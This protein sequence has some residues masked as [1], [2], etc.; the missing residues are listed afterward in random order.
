MLEELTHDA[1][2]RLI[3]DLPNMPAADKMALLDELET[4][5]KRKKLAQ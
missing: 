3:A 1:V 2:S 5:D 4:L